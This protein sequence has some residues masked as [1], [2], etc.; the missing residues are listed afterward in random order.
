MTG[1]KNHPEAA[2]E[3]LVSELSALGKLSHVLLYI[4]YVAK[5][6]DPHVIASGLAEALKNAT[7]QESTAATQI[8]I[9]AEDARFYRVAVPR[10]II[11]ALILRYDCL[12]HAV[13]D[14]LHGRAIDAAPTSLEA[15]YAA[16]RRWTVEKADDPTT[17]HSVNESYKQL[18]RLAVCRNAI[19]HA[20]GAINAAQRGRLLNARWSE[21]EISLLPAVDGLT[22]DDVQKFRSALRTMGNRLIQFVRDQAS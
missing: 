9:S 8:S 6:T 15:D 4:G 14:T 5:S 17:I 10:A 21:E 11:E 1:P 19:V 2:T 7:S 20:G 3:F 12:A 13:A 16:T 18:I 22:Y